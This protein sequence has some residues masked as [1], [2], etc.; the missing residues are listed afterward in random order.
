M[1]KG[2]DYFD[3]ESLSTYK[4]GNVFRRI[5]I[6]LLQQQVEWRCGVVNHV[7]KV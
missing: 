4:Q 7:V 3:A 2:G 5:Q 6:C 1:S